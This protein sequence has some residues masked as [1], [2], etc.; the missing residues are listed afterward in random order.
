M[1]FV[2]DAQQITSP[3]KNIKV[4]ISTPKASNNNREGAVYFKILYK[5]GSDYIEVMPDSRLGILRKDQSFTDA[6]S[7]CGE[8]KETAVNDK[9]EM[10]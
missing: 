6:I 3:N 8:S 9:Y 7:L 1:P 4:V 2:I 5:K 10:T